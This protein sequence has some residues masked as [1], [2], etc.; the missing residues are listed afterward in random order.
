[1]IWDLLIE[2][3]DSYDTIT[4]HEEKCSGEHCPLFAHPRLP[5]LNK[6]GFKTLKAN[7]QFFTPHRCCKPE[8]VKRYTKQEDRVR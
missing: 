7:L 1:M 5:N 2:H 4:Y 6:E 3:V 8:Y